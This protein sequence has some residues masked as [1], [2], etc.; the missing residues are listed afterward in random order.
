MMDGAKEA[1]QRRMKN[2]WNYMPYWVIVGCLGH[3]WDNQLLGTLHAAK[4]DAID[5]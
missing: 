4:I 3:T 2:R 5:A 1:I